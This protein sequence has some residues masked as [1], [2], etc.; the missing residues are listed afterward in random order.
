MRAAVL[1]ISRHSPWAGLAA[2]EN[3]DIALAGGAFDLPIS[4][5]WL[6]EGVWQLLGTQQPQLLEQKNLHAQ[7]SALPLFGVEKLYV[8]QH[9]LDQRGLQL[10]DLAL[11]VE[12]LSNAQIIQL[13]QQHHQVLSL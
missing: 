8:A 10:A 1:L 7:L 13:I 4:I 2:K 9:S 3:L 12:A 5:L 6:D 11:D